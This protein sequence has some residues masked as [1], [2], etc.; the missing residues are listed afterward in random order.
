MNLTELEGER[1][2]GV[3][4]NHLLASGEQNVSGSQFKGAALGVR[5]NP[6]PGSYILGGG[7]P[8]EAARRSL[9]NEGAKFLAAIPYEDALGNVRY[10][11]IGGYDDTAADFSFFQGSYLPI[12]QQ[13]WSN[14]GHRVTATKYDYGRVP[15]PGEYDTLIAEEEWTLGP[16][17]SETRRY[18]KPTDSGYE[19]NPNLT[20]KAG[21]AVARFAASVDRQSVPS[22][23]TEPT[24][25]FHAPVQN[26]DS[27]YAPATGPVQYVDATLAE[28]DGDVVFTVAE[29]DTEIIVTGTNTPSGAKRHLTRYTGA[30]TR[31]RTGIGPPVNLSHSYGGSTSARVAHGSPLS[32]IPGKLFIEYTLRSARRTL[33]QIYSPI[34]SIISGISASLAVNYAVF[35][36]TVGGYD[37]YHVSY[38]VTAT[39]VGR[40]TTVTSYLQAGTFY[41]TDTPQWDWKGTVQ[42]SA[43]RLSGPFVGDQV[44]APQEALDEYGIIP[45]ARPS[46]LVQGRPH[47]ARLRRAS[48][49]A[50]GVPVARCSVLQ[51]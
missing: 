30:L 18:L 7:L 50:G 1:F 43:K 13:A 15:L 6:A 41:T 2:D 21:T 46:H 17:G 47:G 24:H 40:I 3:N 51:G 16:G 25:L 32:S 14:E 42:V 28:R 27:F 8:R 20:W 19:A 37:Y 9:V 38:T 31:Y 29:T 10:F 48:Q 11:E 39:G 22:G 49:G 45:L 23:Y 12:T 5:D 35:Q 26:E 44:T 34:Y 4:V 33:E 36:Q